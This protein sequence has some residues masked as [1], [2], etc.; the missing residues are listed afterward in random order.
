MATPRW[1]ET[2]HRLLEWTNEQGPSERLAAQ[3]LLNEGFTGLDPSHPLGGRDGGKDAVCWKADKRWV[4]G[5]Y[6]PR[7]QQKLRDIEEKFFADLQGAHKNSAEGFAFVTNQELTLGERELLSSRWP[8]RVELY[9]LERITTILDSPSMAGVRKQFLGIDYDDRSQGGRGG[10]AA[11]LSGGTATGG[12][13]GDAGP[14]GD[15]GRGGNAL[16]I[17]EGSWAEGGPGGQGGIGP[18]GR[19]TDAT[20]RNGG[21]SMGG[22]GGGARRSDGRGGKGGRSGGQLLGEF[23]VDADGR[24]FGEGGRG[25]N[26]AAYDGKVATIKLLLREYYNEQPPPV[27]PRD[28]HAAVPLFWLNARLQQMG[29]NWQARIDDD[30][31]FEFAEITPRP[32]VASDVLERLASTDKRVLVSSV[33][34]PSVAPKGI[35]LIISH[36]ITWK[37]KVENSSFPLDIHGTIDAVSVERFPHAIGPFA[38][39]VLISGAGTVP[40]SL[41]LEAPNGQIVV[42]RHNVANNW[43]VIGTWQ[44]PPHIDEFQLDQAG[45]YRWKVCHGDDVLLDR[46]MVVR[47]RE[48][49]IAG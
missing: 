18:G 32:A 10:D 25:A 15:G 33:E 34:S 4:M 9:H 6:F 20:A 47:L 21:R 39:Y 13:G 1:D 3:V 48:T 42:A 7:G 38:A 22:E 31:E 23:W 44:W 11:A 12:T 8:H 24:H 17:G 2:W 28:D 30:G 29:T 14:N 41:I 49:E 43:G 37:S 45:L 16:S 35:A 19:G 40:I 46:P 26:S 27:S 36:G 5:V